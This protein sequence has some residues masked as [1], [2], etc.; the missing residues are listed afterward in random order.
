MN[1]NLS[2]TELALCQPVTI[3]VKVTNVGEQEGSYNVNLEVTDRNWRLYRSYSG[4]Y[5]GSKRVTLRG[6]E[7]EI[8]EFTVVREEA[9]VWLVEVAGLKGKFTVLAPK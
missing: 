5:L 4:Y 3:N 9:G 6:R 2:P 1:L 7:S 8:V